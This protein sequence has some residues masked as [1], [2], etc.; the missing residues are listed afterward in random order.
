L[1]ADFDSV[2]HQ[3]IDRMADVERG[4]IM[5]SIGLK[6]AGKF[7]A[8]TR[9]DE[10]VVKLPAERVRKL[11]DS[12]TG[13]PFRSGGRVMR[14]WVTLEPSNSTEMATYVVAAHD[15]VAALNAKE[16]Q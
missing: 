9:D 16:Q 15:F 13:Q 1:I 11:I 2:A 8:F 12:A 3:L 4:R 7:F 6:T 5:R 10:L 14:E